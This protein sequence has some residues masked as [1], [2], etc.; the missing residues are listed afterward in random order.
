[1]QAWFAE[2]FQELKTGQEQVNQS[3]NDLLLKQSDVERA[4][5]EAKQQAAAEEARLR[6]LR[7][8]LEA[9]DDDLT[10]REK[11]LADKL[12]A[13]DEEIDK[14]VAQWAQELEQKHKETLEALTTNHVGKLKEAIDAAETAEDAKNLLEEKVKRLETDLEGHGKELSTLKTEREKTLHSLMEMQVA[15]SDK[16][17]QLSSAT[18]S[19]ED[20]KVKLSTLEETLE[21]AKAREKTLIKDLQD[22]RDL[23]KSV[24]ASH[25]DYVAGVQVWTEK[26]VDVAEKLAAQLSTM[27]LQCFRYSFD[28]RVSTSTK[29]TM[30]FNRVLEALEQ[31]HSDRTTHLASESRKLC[32][33]VLCKMLVKVVHKNPDINLNVLDRLPKD[34]DVKALEELVAPI[35]DRVSQVKRVEGDRRD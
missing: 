35:V 16:T 24:A 26:L 4:Q 5:E 31:L 3:W 12:R 20:L 29:L 21:T 6:E 28:D 9:H 23:L 34:V 15:I 27:G 7:V 10:A 11:A 22:E 25:N 13:K 18:D 17:K 8:G 14:L 1:M 2:A 33:A 32:Q 19:I 30:F